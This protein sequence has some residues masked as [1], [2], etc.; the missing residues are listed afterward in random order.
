MKIII[1]DSAQF[2]R[3][4]NMLLKEIIDGECYFK[5]YQDLLASIPKYRTVFVQSNTFWSLTTNALL[6][7]TLTRLC[8][9]YDQ[10][11]KSL[12]IC[13]LLDTI[14]ANLAIFDTSNFRK[15]LKDNPFVGSLSQTA[16]KPDAKKLKKDI[17]TVSSSAPLVKKLIILRNNLIAHRRASNVVEDF[18][19]TKHYVITRDEIT[20]LLSR[21]TSILNDYSSLFR[22]SIFSTKIVGHDDYLY[23]LNAVNE[24]F[25]RD[26]DFSKK[27]SKR[28][29]S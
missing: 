27:I 10:N 6:D 16:R 2:E 26:R 12:S 8:R 17:E 5:L 13:N 18:D 4:L 23:I 14:E 20:S 1:K 21:A 7:G 24:K 9:V 3:L 22:A 11:T 25:E 15:R 28:L 19:I 29:A